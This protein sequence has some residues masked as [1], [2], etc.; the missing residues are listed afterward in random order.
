MDGEAGG[1][2]V[3]RNE[4]ATLA[5]YFAVLVLI[6]ACQRPLWA[7]TDCEAGNGSLDSAEPKTISSQQVIQ[8]F[9]P[10][11][12]AAKNARLRYTYTQD[13]LMQTLV[14]TK[15]TGV[16][17]E[18]TTVSYDAKGNRKEDVTFAAQSTLRGVQIT[19]EDME[20][21]RIFM[22]LMLTSEDL[23]EYTLSYSGQQ[24]V[25]D[26]DTYVFHVEPKKEEKDR[27][28]FKGRVWVDAQDFQIVKVCGK[29][30]PERI[31][32]K[33]RQRPELHP[34]F[35][36]YRQL[37]GGQWFPVYARSDD[38]LDFRDGPVHLRQI[39]KFSNYKLAAN[40]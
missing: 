5:V 34:M 22:P 12:T 15:V 36:T 10:A 27:R 16:F 13:V 39:V 33:K 18:V 29:S 31:A 1:K 38:T 35:V 8:K 2:R 19:K 30:G 37:V 4:A 23:K 9:G 17:H 21:I 7:Q 3:A 24:H 6:L 20:D 28:Y 26:L 40:P 32:T 25:D 11:E 14:G